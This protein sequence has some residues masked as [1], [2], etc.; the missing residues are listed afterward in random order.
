MTPVTIQKGTK[1]SMTL[2][3]RS[4]KRM[5]FETFSDQNLVN[6]FKWCLN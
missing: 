5:N 4:R 1:N 3:F 2:E 6:I